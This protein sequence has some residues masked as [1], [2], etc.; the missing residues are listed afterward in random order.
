MCSSMG[1]DPVVEEA[2]LS[3]ACAYIRKPL[4]KAVVLDTLVSV[5]DMD[6]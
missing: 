2:A 4:D 1:H 6:F 5:E 3:G